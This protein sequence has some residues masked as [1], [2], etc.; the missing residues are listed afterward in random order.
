M[1]TILLR[2]NGDTRSIDFVHRNHFS[3]ED[4]IRIV[5][6]GSKSKADTPTATADETISIQMLAE[7]GR[8][9]SR[10]IY[11]F[12]LIVDSGR[13]YGLRHRDIFVA[14]L[15]EQAGLGRGLWCQIAIAAPS[16]IQPYLAILVL[17]APHRFV[18]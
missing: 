10:C 7:S 11:D 12:R 4:Q 3:N 8:A 13:L 17:L 15:P 18:V 5:C 1:S 14:H 6:K 16:A 2:E 9:R